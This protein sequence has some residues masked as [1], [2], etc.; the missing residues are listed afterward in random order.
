[1]LKALTGG[2][3]KQ[4]NPFPAIAFGLAIIVVGLGGFMAWAALANI[5]GAIVTSGTLK[6]MSNRKKVQASEGG[7][8]RQLAVRNGTRVKAGDILLLLDDTKAR[9]S[10]GIVQ[11]SYDLLRATVARLHAELLRAETI[12]LP[13][14]LVKRRNDKIV[15]D[16]LAGQRQLFEARSTALKGQNEMLSERIGRLEEEITGLEAQSSAKTE[17]I[18]IISLEHTDLNNLLKKGLAPRTRVLVLKR[19]MSRLKGEKGSQDAGIARTRRQIAE[20]RLEQLQL[21]NN[22]NKEIS[23]ELG[24]KETEMFGLEERV[25]AARHALDQTVIRATENGIVVD[26]NVHTVGG[27]I[28][29][30][31]TVLEIVPTQDNLFVEVR[32]RPADIDN[33]AVGMKADIVFSAFSQRELPRLSGDVVYVSADVLTDKRTDMPYYIA[34]ASISENTLSKLKTLKLVPGMPADVMIRTGERTPLA[35]LTQPMRDSLSRAW[36][37]P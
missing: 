22:F 14:D 25:A 24:A 4:S 33:I 12:T 34:H 16:I 6:V 29:P 35:Y 13:A 31:A 20:T 32:V 7:T 23:D 21:M 26:L 18:D 11:N 27:V 3:S 10:L 1:M 5:S 9:S 19:E 36:R 15:A 17:Q 2:G 8:V 28:Q 37:E 30:G